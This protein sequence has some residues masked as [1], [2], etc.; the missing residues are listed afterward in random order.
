MGHE[1]VRRSNM[2]VTVTMN[3]ALD[4]S[5]KSSS[6]IAGGLNRL[7]DI[8]IDAGGKGINVSKMIGVLGGASIATGFLGGSSGRDILGALQAQSIKTDFVSIASSSRINLKVLTDRYGI[9]EF[10]EPG[11]TV[12][13]AEVDALCAKLMGY[14]RP[15]SIIVFS[16]SLPQGVSPDIYQK[17]I[18]EVRSA[19]ASVF[20]DADGEAF[21]LALSSRPDYIKPNKF[22]LAQYFN[23]REDC[24]M[25]ECVSLCRRLIGKGIKM[26]ALSMGEQGAVFVTKQENLYSPGVKVETVSTVGAG[27]CM[28]GAM[29]H[30]LSLGMPIKDLAAMAMAASAGSVTTQGTNPP[31]R[32]TFAEILRQVKFQNVT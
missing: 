19:G 30:A 21:S 4:K 12:T 32:E 3:P 18:R 20:L 10:N 1:N 31:T 8:S 16:G 13:P 17:L 9:T 15:G 6:I 2:I 24:G 29:V 14:A 27:D 5:A 25:S 11:P 7:S 28:V 23:V 26:V 22:E